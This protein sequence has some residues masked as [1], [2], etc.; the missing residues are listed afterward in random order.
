M[1]VSMLLFLVVNSHPLRAEGEATATAQDTPE[2]KALQSQYRV[3][4]Q[5]ALRPVR[6]RYV[7]QLQ[8]LIRSFTARGNVA[9]AV[10]V[11]AEI[12]AVKNSTKEDAGGGKPITHKEIEKEVI[13]HWTYGSP[14]SWLGIR[15]DGKAYHEKAVMT[16]TINAEKSLVLTDP[17]QPGKHATLVFDSSVNSFTG[18]D[19]DGKHVAGIRRDRD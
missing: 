13:G 14:N 12:D 10:A 5:N 11:Q 19:F 2:L 4:S 1:L 8:A 18:S 9:A 16:W 7:G 17:A 6:E 3:D 15:P